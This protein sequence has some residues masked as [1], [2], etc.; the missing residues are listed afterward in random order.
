MAIK[1]SDMAQKIKPSATLAV[2]SKAKAMV[3]EGIDVVNFGVGEPD[4]D[5]PQNIKIAGV[6]AIESGFTKYTPASGIPE[7]KE[8]IC[9]K[10]SKENG[11]TYQPDQ[12]IVSC[13]GKHSI[14]NLLYVLCDA[15]DDVIIP[16]PYWLSY[17][18]MAVMVGGVPVIVPTSEETGF[19]LTK[20]ALAEKVTPKSKVMILNS[21]SNPTG[22]GY[23]K[24]DLRELVG[25]AIEKGIVVISDEMYEKI[26]YDGF[27]HAS[28]ASFGE[29]FRDMVIT[30]NG[31]SK[32]Y[33]MTGWRI[34]YAAGPTEVIKACGTIQSQVTSG[35][36]AMAQ[37]AAV[38][39]LIGDQSEVPKMVAE[40]DKR[41]KV[42]VKRL[43][44]M[45]D[46]SC[47]TPIGAFYA[48]PN[49]SKHYGRKLGGKVVENSIGM[50]NYLLEHAR[51]AAVPGEPF[52]ADDHIR[53]S[54]ATSMKRIE[55]GMR[56]MAK[57]LK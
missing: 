28:P 55:E 53:F 27:Q 40:F 44:A 14:Y 3:K 2:S 12:V 46:V 15:G 42:I 4:F 57:A 29:E 22:M 54:Y 19:K 36:N 5:T 18:D 11:V 45:K 23:T 34:G 43:N 51:V 39:A 10:L 16:A 24:E 33:A 9:E 38:E 13:G 17:S 52:G 49:V 8:A 32:T 7:L 30:V 26:V 47:V 56:R 41:R 25:F 6:K 31:V 48:F 20:E 1:L 21:P 50:C 35:P 37:K